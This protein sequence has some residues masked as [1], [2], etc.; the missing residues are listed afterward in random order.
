MEFEST[1]A[2]RKKV[3]SFTYKPQ[4]SSFGHVLKVGDGIFWADGLEGLQLSE[5]V[6]LP[7]EIY[8]MALSLSENYN[9]IALLNGEYDVTEGMEVRGTGHVVQVP[10]EGLEGRIV[11]PIGRPLDGQGPIQSLKFRP[12][13]HEAPSIIDRDAVERPLQTGWLAI[14]AMVPI[15][16]GQRELIIGDRQTGK[17]SLAV[18]TIINQRG[19]NVRC[20][21][22]AIGQKI[23]TVKNVMEEL[24]HHN[25]LSYTTV[26]FSGASDPAPM[27]YIAPY[28]GC[29][30]AEYVMEQ[31]GD[32]L[33]VYDDLSK[34]AVAYR[35]M[36]LL[37]RRPPGREAYPGD[38]F[39]LHS[40]LLERAAQ[41]SAKKGG[42]SVTAL[43]IVET[44]AGDISAYIPTNVISITDGQ[45][46]LEENLFHAGIRP[47]LNVGLSVSRV[48]GAA[49]TQAVRKSAG[50]LRLDLSQYREMKVFSQFGSDLDD[51]TRELL[52]YGERLTHI[53]VQDRYK[54]MPE[55]DQDVIL[56]TM[57]QKGLVTDLEQTRW[58]QQ[59][60]IPFIKQSYPQ[61]L[62]QL[63]KDHTLTDDIREWIVDAAHEFLQQKAE[64]KSKAEAAKAKAVVQ[65][66]EQ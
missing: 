6:E 8:G 33:I 29:A 50:Q 9:G 26:I 19:R 39:Y 53:M 4:I 52:S 30:M 65:E 56:Y 49:Q 64:E 24:A 48:G 58:V 31:G 35:S 25:A 17:T 16:K 13:E 61:I 60:F 54:P 1:D 46:F 11:D 66:N 14:D 38:V 18:D 44:M 23:S 37:L 5:L 59:E 51:S 20:F 3:D 42:G 63:G 40:R 47:A 28:A 45:I 10:V 41:L 12:V 32:A 34:H 36:S 15:G 62:A 21:Y 43:P 7:G 27:Q 22:V 57:T 2:M 55:D